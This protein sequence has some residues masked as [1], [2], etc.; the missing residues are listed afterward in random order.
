MVSKVNK[1]ENYTQ[2]LNEIKDELI[3]IKSELAEL[4]KHNKYTTNVNEKTNRILVGA[5][6]ILVAFGFAEIAPIANEPIF[7]DGLF[8][9]G[10]LSGLFFVTGLI[11]ITGI[12][13]LLRV[14]IKRIIDNYKAQ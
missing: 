2:I 4:N 8:Y 11:T 5:T 13:H 9:L 1:T 12:F 7:S 14:K 6:F 3:I 10:L